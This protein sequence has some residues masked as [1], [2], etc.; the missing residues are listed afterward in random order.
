VLFW[1]WKPPQ[2]FW[3]NQWSFWWT[4]HRLTH[5][6]GVDAWRSVG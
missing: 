4:C 1:L 2:K 5:D 3:C 6:A